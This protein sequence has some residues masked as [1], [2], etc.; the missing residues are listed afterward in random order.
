M[1]I[2]FKPTEWEPVIRQVITAVLDELRADEAKVDGRIGYTE[3]EAAALLG[4][5]RHALRDCRL[6]GEIEAS[7][8]GKRIV[9]ERHE[10][11]AFL[12]RQRIQ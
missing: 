8:V 4:I 12:R 7:K 10:L 3:P 6:R 1:K 11:M 9:Y 2:E 5:E